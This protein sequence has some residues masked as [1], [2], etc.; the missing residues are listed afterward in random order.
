MAKLEVGQKLVVYE[1][2]QWAKPPAY[3]RTEVTVTKVGRKWADVDASWFG[4]LDVER[5]HFKDSYPARS[6]YTSD[7]EFKK[8]KLFDAAIST[9]HKEFDHYGSYHYKEKFRLEQLLGVIRA[10]GLREP[11]VEETSYEA[12]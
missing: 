10:L 6:V 9:L 3:K 8:E 1:W 4:K 7:E 2:K 12:L 11:T 5:M